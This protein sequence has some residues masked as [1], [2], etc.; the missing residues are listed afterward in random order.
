MGASPKILDE[1]AK[2]APSAINEIS[3]DSGERQTLGLIT[4]SGLN[5]SAMVSDIH[6]KLNGKLSTNCVYLEPLQVK[7]INKLATIGQCFLL[8]GCAQ[9]I[10]TQ[11]HRLVE[12]DPQCF[13]L[14][15]CK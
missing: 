4:E 1:M 7:A 6:C 12:N 2:A 15:G 9:Q 5:V 3:Y 10:E 14:G 8:G 13:I 11:A